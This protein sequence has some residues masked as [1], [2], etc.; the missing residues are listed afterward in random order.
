[1]TEQQRIEKLGE[2][3]AVRWPTEWPL[4]VRPWRRQRRK[5]RRYCRLVRDREVAHVRRVG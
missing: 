3:V 2:V 5:S 1:M 4:A